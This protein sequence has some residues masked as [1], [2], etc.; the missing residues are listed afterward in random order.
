MSCETKRGVIG[1]P[2]VVEP[3]PVDNHLAFVLDQVRNVEVAI[4]VPNET[5]EMPSAPPPFEYSPG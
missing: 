1:I 3:V 5:H 4:A 2:V